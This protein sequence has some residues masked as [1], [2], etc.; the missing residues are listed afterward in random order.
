MR[1]AD[2]SGQPANGIDATGVD[3]RD[4]HRDVAGEARL[5]EPTAA[6]HAEE[7]ALTRVRRLAMVRAASDDE[8]EF[9]IRAQ[10]QLLL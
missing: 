6:L 7:L 8:T 2:V 5:A 10:F 9:V 1:A 3:R 4:D